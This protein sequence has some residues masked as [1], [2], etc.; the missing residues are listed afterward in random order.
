M[1]LLFGLFVSGAAA[2]AIDL[3]LETHVSAPAMIAALDLVQWTHARPEPLVQSILDYYAVALG[4]TP[5]TW[6]RFLAV[7]A[8][9]VVVF[10]TVLFRTT[11]DEAREP[12]PP[13]KRC[14]RMLNLSAV[15]VGASATVAFPLLVQIMIWLRGLHA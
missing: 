12:T 13:L 11:P 4:R 15:A 2:F 5:W 8:V 1:T 7:H 3:V 9:M 10:A 6:L 14:V